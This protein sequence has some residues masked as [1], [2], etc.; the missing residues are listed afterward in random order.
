MKLYK[1]LLLYMAGVFLIFGLGIFL[2]YRYR[3]P[4]IIEKEV[5]KYLPGKVIKEIVEIPTPYAVFI[6]SDPEYIYITD[7]PGISI[8]DS[9]AIVSD[10]I[11]KRNYALTLF[12]NDTLG[13]L[14]LDLSIQ[15]NQLGNL[16]YEFNPITKVIEKTVG[17]KYQPFLMGGF[18][19]NL[20]GTL[21]GGIYIKNISYSFQWV[22]IFN[23][24]DNFNKNIYLFQVGYKF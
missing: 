18:G 10:W 9:S 19:T 15:Y 8:I 1:K 5:I 20:T 23:A 14:D 17:R 24:P 21:Q 16:T 11:K 12:N 7:S 4:D 22:R 6:P 2:G 3:S 13:K